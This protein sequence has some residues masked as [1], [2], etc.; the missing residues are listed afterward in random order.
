MH[1]LIRGGK[2]RQQKEKGNEDPLTA[3]SLTL[4][5]RTALTDFPLRV[6]P[7]W[8]RPTRS[9]G[10]MRWGIGSPE[11]RLEWLRM[12]IAERERRKEKQKK[13]K[14]SGL[15]WWVGVPED[16]SFLLF[17]FLLSFL[18]GPI[19]HAPVVTCNFAF[20]SGERKRKQNSRKLSTH[21]VAR[22]PQAKTLLL[23]MW[24]ELARYPVFSPVN[25]V[26]FFSPLG[27]SKARFPMTASMH[28][29]N[30]RVHYRMVYIVNYI[31]PNEAGREKPWD[32]QRN[33]HTPLIS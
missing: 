8:G 26:S 19:N 4:L 17:F 30:P 18:L 21:V 7:F 3:Q 23:A 16:L 24:R 29:S 25:L 1:V 2:S 12:Q 33:K 14:N 20:S 11:T 32:P 22:L 13:R 5:R 27:V 28:S 15:T 10:D 9:S 6:F 31:V